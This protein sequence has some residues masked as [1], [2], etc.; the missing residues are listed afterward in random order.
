VFLTGAIPRITDYE[1][2]GGNFLAEKDGELVPDNLEDD[3]AMVI[4]HPDGLIIIDAVRMPALSIPLST[5]AAELVKPK[6]GLL[7]AALIL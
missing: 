5:P 6:S 3:M 7:L 4:D 1:D 2:V